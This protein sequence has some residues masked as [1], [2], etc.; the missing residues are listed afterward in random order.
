MQLTR[1]FALQRACVAKQSHLFTKLAPI[2]ACGLMLLA[3]GPSLL[4]ADE[5]K[6]TAKTAPAK[7]APVQKDVFKKGLP[8]NVAD[9]LAIEKRIQ[10]HIK[11]LTAATV[12]VLIGQSHG[13]GVIVSK[14]GYVMTAAH[15]SGAVGRT[16]KIILPNG[17][18]VQGKTLGLNRR[19]DAGMIKIADPGEW[20]FVE[21]ADAN[22]AKVG[23]WCLATGHPGGFQAGRPPVLRLG[24]I[25][26]TRKTVVQ[27]GCTLVGGDSGGPL[28][29]MDGKVIG[30]HS[31][32]GAPTSWNFHVPVGAYSEDW[33]R[34]VASEDWGGRP[35]PGGPLLGVNGEDHDKGCKVTG[36]APNSAAGNAG[37]Q[38][39]DVITAFEGKPVKGFD[40][41]VD[42]I[43]KKKAGEEA[44]LQILRGEENIEATVTL[45]KRE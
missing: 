16:V 34:L 42:L 17:K 22:A 41:L 43:A 15:V 28:F 32:I 11:K 3:A 23:D 37:V 40:G 1:Y 38:V 21:L 2:A 8:E 12:G 14:D 7:T 39:N 31:R 10:Q 13:S 9:L 20:P 24:R 33:D 6:D 26:L 30:I 36:V 5:T 18:V 27:T 4:P 19:V 44:K 25:V 29:N 35:V 45:G